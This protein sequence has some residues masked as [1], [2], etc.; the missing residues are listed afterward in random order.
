MNVEYPV[1]AICEDLPARI[2]RPSLFVIAVTF[3]IYIQ[4]LYIAVLLLPRLLLQQ[5]AYPESCHSCE[6]NISKPVKSVKFF[7]HSCCSSGRFF[8]SSMRQPSLATLLSMV[9]CRVCWSSTDTAIF[10]LT[11]FIAQIV[12]HSLPPTSQISLD[13][14]LTK[15]WVKQDGSFTL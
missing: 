8:P 1:T 11:L 12:V 14:G 13:Y 15:V 10:S 3:I 9:C 5:C 2:S 7:A 6:P 4:H